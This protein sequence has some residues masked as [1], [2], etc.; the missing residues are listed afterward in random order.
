MTPDQPPAKYQDYYCQMSYK[1]FL[2]H[3]AAGTLSAGTIS[4]RTD[5]EPR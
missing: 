4:T 5:Q 3:E 1:D 2:L